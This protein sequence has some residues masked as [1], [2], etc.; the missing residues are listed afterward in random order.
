MYNRDPKIQLQLADNQS[1]GNPVPPNISG[2]SK[3]LG[4]VTDYRSTCFANGTHLPVDAGQ[5]TH[6]YKKA[7]VSQQKYYNMWTFDNSPLNRQ[8]LEEEYG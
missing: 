1:Y 3:H 4:G 8:G 2:E 7:Q 5:S 6:L